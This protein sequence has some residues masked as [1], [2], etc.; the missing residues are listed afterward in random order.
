MR[1]SNPFLGRFLVGPPK[2]FLKPYLEDS[3]GAV[4]IGLGP[5]GKVSSAVPARW[6]GPFP[7]LAGIEPCEQSSACRPFLRRRVRRRYPLLVATTMPGF[8]YL[9]WG[10]HPQALPHWFPGGCA[11]DAFT[12]HLRYDPQFRPGPPDQSRQEAA[13]AAPRRLGPYSLRFN[14]WSSPQSPKVGYPTERAICRE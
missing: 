1:E 7:D 8:P 10:R 14:P 4:A 3:K 12:V 9:L 11:N 5:S 13:K 2:V 6:A